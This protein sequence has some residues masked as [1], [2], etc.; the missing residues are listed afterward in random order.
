ME[1]AKNNDLLNDSKFRELNKEVQKSQ[2]LFKTLNSL[3]FNNGQVKIEEKGRANIKAHMENFRID[4]EAREKTIQSIDKQLKTFEINVDKDKLDNSIDKIEII[5]N[6]VVK[7]R[8]LISEIENLN[9]RLEGFQKLFENGLNEINKS[10]NKNI[11]L[12]FAKKHDIQEKIADS[13]FKL[14]RKKDEKITTEKEL[15]R[16]IEE[17][18]KVKVQLEDFKKSYDLFLAK[19]DIKNDPRASSDISR[20]AK[21]EVQH[22]LDEEKYDKQFIEL[23]KELQVIEAE[24]KK[25]LESWLVKEEKLKHNIQENELKASKLK[26]HIESGDLKINNKFEAIMHQNNSLT[27]SSQIVRENLIIEAAELKDSISKAEAIISNNEDRKKILIEEYS[28]QDFDKAGSNVAAIVDDLEQ[29]IENCTNS[30]NMATRQ[31]N[32]HKEKLKQI[33]KQ[34]SEIIKIE[35][36]VRD[37]V[38]ENEY[39]V[40]REEYRFID[41]NNAKS[42]DIVNEKEKLNWI[43]HD[44]E[45]EKKDINRKYMK[46]KDDWLD[47]YRS[48]RNTENKAKEDYLEAKESIKVRL[49]DLKNLTNNRL[50]FFENKI[51]LTE[52]IIFTKTEELQNIQNKLKNIEAQINILK[53]DIDLF[54]A[55]YNKVKTNI[56]ILRNK[57]FAKRKTE[58]ELAGESLNDKLQHEK[59]LLAD[60]FKNKIKHIINSRESNLDIFISGLDDL[61]TWNKTAERFLYNCKT[62]YNMSLN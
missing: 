48:V 29:S 59:I 41:K 11:S 56:D 53:V 20:L 51:T 6:L 38:I 16:K 44:L 60:K 33:E 52:S 42:E 10:S 58:D 7:K 57:H 61:F 32:A 30:I 47:K 50:N 26:S 12:A 23:N 36:D 27:S 55:Q 17:I 18:D 19:E 22:R 5:N 2:F 28:S 9:W 54:T 3:N 45:Q 39:E 15:R 46:L 4:I 31:L 13:N 24:N 8:K 14:E 43:K 40:A 35:K 1:K 21:L 37:K 34:L 25:L 62:K 49:Q